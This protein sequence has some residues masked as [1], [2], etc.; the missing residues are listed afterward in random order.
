[1]SN[2]FKLSTSNKR[3]IYLRQYIESIREPIHLTEF[4]KTVI[5][6]MNLIKKI[7]L[8]I[9]MRNTQMKLLHAINE[10]FD[11]NETKLLKPKLEGLDDLR[12]DEVDG[13]SR[14]GRKN[15]TKKI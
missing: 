11:F 4:Y 6:G 1:M 15:G 3:K 14:R 7:Q 12:L 9:L 13:G 5:T 8:E 10:G 2:L